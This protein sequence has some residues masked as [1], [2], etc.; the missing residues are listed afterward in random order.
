MVYI[1]I[2]FVCLVIVFMILFIGMY[3]M[4]GLGGLFIILNLLGVE[5]GFGFI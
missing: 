2:L 5:V 3:N 4:E 1:D